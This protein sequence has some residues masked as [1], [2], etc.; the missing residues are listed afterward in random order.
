MQKSVL[1]LLC[2]SL[3]LPHLAFA[4]ASGFKMDPGK[5]R[6]WN[7]GDKD[8]FPTP[9][10]A[11]FEKGDKTL[12][13]VG[14]H[15]VDPSSTYNLIEA[16]FLRFAPEIVVVESLAFALGENPKSHLNDYLS[17]TKEEI[18][19]NPSLGPGTELLAITK[20]IP[21]IGGEPTIEEQM[22]NPF[23]LGM[24]FTSEDILNTQILQRLPYR[25]DQL[26][27]KEP[28]RFFE[29]AMDLYRIKGSRPDF[30]KRF[31][32]WYKRRTQKEFDYQ[33]VTKDNSAV[34]CSKDDTFIQKVACAF[35]MAR[36]RFLVE[37][38][39]LLLNK[40]DRVL[41]VYGTGH[42]VQEYP[43]LTA[44]FS[45]AP[46]YFGSEPLTGARPY[47]DLKEIIERQLA[48]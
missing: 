25:R 40:Y 38:M 11:V 22:T 35:N 30:E 33:K 7:K 20:K 9:L 41:V 23:L 4:A 32:A 39:E 21:V 13:F 26:G 1:A 12:I 46:D 3:L 15:H 19:K 5:V 14:D 45:K 47:D 36:D 6:P 43:A 29:Y 28:A 37:R 48:N 16:A 34:N 8:Q 27:F 10:G 2:L 17:K 18:W 42:F 31:A 44:A 24:G